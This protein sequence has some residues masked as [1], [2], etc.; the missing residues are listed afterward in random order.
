MENRYPKV[1]E[2]DLLIDNFFEANTEVKF[3]PEMKKLI[4][5]VGEDLAS[6]IMWCFFILIDPRSFYYDKMTIIERK[7]HC[8]KEYYDLAFE[9]YKW[10]EEFYLDKIL[11]NEDILHYVQLL[12]KFEMSVAMDSKY[13]VQK[14]AQD[15]EALIIF[16]QKAYAQINKAETLT[17]QG[18]KQPGLLARTKKF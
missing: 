3:Y 8:I 10:V 6:K 12:K 5:D 7:N 18:K 15:K 9:E 11:I 16:R 1:I 13:T 17:I 14:A 4:A 2:G